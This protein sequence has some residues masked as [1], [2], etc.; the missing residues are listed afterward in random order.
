MSSKT[1]I[2]TTPKV[3]SQYKTNKSD[4]ETT[5]SNDEDTESSDAEDGSDQDSDDD[6]GPAPSAEQEVSDLSDS[7]VALNVSATRDQQ[8]HEEEATFLVICQ[9]DLKCKTKKC[10][11]FAS[12]RLKCNAYCH[13]NSTKCE[14]K[15]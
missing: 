9:C 11:C 10:L 7:F 15:Q 12:G 6:T 4:E 2:E 1:Q 3:A 13:K 5:Q 14:N 8:T